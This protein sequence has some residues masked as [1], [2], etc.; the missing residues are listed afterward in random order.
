LHLEIKDNGSGFDVEAQMN[1]SKSFG[2]QSILQRA[3]AIMA[4][5]KIN[6]SS[7]GTVILLKIPV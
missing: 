2:L 7:T 3:K 1:N 5:V 4:K 6:S